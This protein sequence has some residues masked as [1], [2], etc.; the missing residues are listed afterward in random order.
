MI[1]IYLYTIICNRFLYIQAKSYVSGCCQISST[2]FNVII[3]NS[4]H[5]LKLN[6]Y[7]I[8]LCTAYLTAPGDIIF[9]MY[10]QKSVKDCSI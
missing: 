10:I 5:A 9:G 4:D 8:K 6:Y 7:H 3:T 2:Q 1:Q